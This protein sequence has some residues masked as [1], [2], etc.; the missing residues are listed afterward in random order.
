MDKE[1][2]KVFWT[3][4]EKAQEGFAKE[5]PWRQLVKDKEDFVRWRWGKG[6]PFEGNKTG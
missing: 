3:L 6:T 4:H 1:Q 2:G 5:R